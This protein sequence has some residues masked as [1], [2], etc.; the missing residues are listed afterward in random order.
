MQS[1]HVRVNSQPV[2]KASFLVSAGDVLTFMQGRQGR[3]VRVVAM[4]TRRG[5]AAEAQALYEDLTPEPEATSARVG[6]RPT[7]RDRRVMEAW[8]SSQAPSLDG[9]AQD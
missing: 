4:G 6:A 5:P 8:R 7:K 1:G 2:G 3:V 9:D